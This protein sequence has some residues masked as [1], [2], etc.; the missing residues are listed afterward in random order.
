MA[1]IDDMPHAILAILL[2][3][4]DFFI[5]EKTSPNLCQRGLP[6]A[7]FFAPLFCALIAHLFRL[8]RACGGVRFACPILDRSPLRRPLAEGPN[9]P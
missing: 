9:P 7:F 8:N 6:A 4:A 5:K 3:Q 2:A 1:I